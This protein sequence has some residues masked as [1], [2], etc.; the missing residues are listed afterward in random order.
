MNFSSIRENVNTRFA[1]DTIWLIAAQAVLMGAGLG[2]NLIIGKYNGADDL[3]VFNQSLALYTILSTLFAFGL[4]NTIT[5]EISDGSKTKQQQNNVLLTNMIITAALSALLSLLVITASIVLPQ[6]F[7]S[8][9]LA[10]VVYIPMFALPFFNLN[11]NIG[12]YYSGLRKQKRFAI[13]RIMRW[14][15]MIGWVAGC[16]WMHASLDMFLWCFP[17]SEL[18]VFLVNIIELIPQLRFKP[19]FSE[20]G[21]HVKFGMKSYVAELISVLNASLDV[22]LIGYFLTNAETGIYS[23]ILFF[24]KTLAV[25]PG[26]LMQ[27]FSPI[28][29]RLWES[30]DIKSIQLRVQ[31]IRKI[32][33]RVVLLKLVFLLAAYPIITS[34]IKQDFQQTTWLFVCA[35]IGPFLFALIAWSGSMLIMTNKLNE[36]IIRT[37]SIIVLS[38]LSTIALTALWGLTG[39]CVACSVNGLFA[40]WTT[41]HMIKKSLSIKVI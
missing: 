10:E 12:A 23:F 38:A 28:V 11:K 39:A 30:G 1:K 5:K 40:F 6:I 33:T 27:N 8:I 20:T 22:L 3:G 15:I 14:I 41:R 25:F 2:L 4:N 29:S 37:A 7:S 21:K 19:D 32:N 34:F 16:E 36:N 26:I 31:S 9:E 35:L 24:V 18:L 17:V 13:Q